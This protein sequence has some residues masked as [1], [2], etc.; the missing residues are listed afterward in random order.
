MTHVVTDNCIKCK[1]GTCLSV[2]PVLC[3]HEADD[4][5]VINPVECVDCTMCVEVCEA[6]A[7]YHID[8]VPDEQSHFILLNAELSKL[9]P[10]TTKVNK[11]THD[12]DAMNG[13]PN[14]LSMVNIT[15][16]EQA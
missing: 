11:V 2:C 1:Y 3:F 5:L 12:P 10:V 14:K 6:N 7:I 4:F 13:I 8:S 15:L 16:V 9:L